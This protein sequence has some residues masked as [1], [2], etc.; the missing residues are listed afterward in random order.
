MVDHQIIISVPTQTTNG[1][2]LIT[3]IYN[4][5]CILISLK[6]MRGITDVDKSMVNMYITRATSI[7]STK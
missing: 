6:N 2:Q 3:Q 5:L 4:K 7:L 1:I